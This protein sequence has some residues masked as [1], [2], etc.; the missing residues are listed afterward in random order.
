MNKYLIFLSLIIPSICL[1]FENK[2]QVY[3]EWQFVAHD[4]QINFYYVDPSSIGEKNGFRYYKELTDFPF[5][6]GGAMSRVVW[7]IADCEK[8]KAREIVATYYDQ[9]GAK[10]NEIETYS[11]LQNPEMRWLDASTPKTVGYMILG[12]VCEA[13]SI[14]MTKFNF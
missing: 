8:M 11:Y 6:R 2:Y 14:T 10:G 5:I 1:S 7:I 4:Q 3:N 9:K 13:P 12:Y